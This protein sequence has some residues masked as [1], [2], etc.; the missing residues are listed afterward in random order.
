MVN[1]IISLGE[2][3]TSIW[4]SPTIKVRK[5]KY[6]KII[7]VVTTIIVIIKTKI[8]KSDF[9]DMALMHLFY[10]IKLLDSI[11]FYSLSYTVLYNSL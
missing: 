11:L 6:S 10:F 7:V 4:V 2:S 9:L 5:I 3:L 1:L 8:K